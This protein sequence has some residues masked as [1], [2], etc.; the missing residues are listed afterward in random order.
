MCS[1]YRCGHA[2][3]L[4]IISNSI[5]LLASSKCGE[6]IKCVARIIMFI[7][8]NLIGMEMPKLNMTPLCVCVFFWKAS[9]LNGMKLCIIAN[10]K[11]FEGYVN[12]CYMK[13]KLLTKAEQNTQTHPKNPSLHRKCLT[14]TNCLIRFWR[15]FQ[16]GLFI[17]NTWVE[18]SS[19]AT[20][21]FSFTTCLQS[22]SCVGSTLVIYSE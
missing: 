14:F 15:D 12:S 10:K 22:S 21:I 16:A 4:A 20:W 18:W 13:W 7:R 8:E 2:L 9:K 1:L 11:S 5:I 17:L 19:I 6:G 3:W